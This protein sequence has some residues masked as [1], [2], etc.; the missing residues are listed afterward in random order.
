MIEAIKFGSFFIRLC[1]LCLYASVNDARARA[2][3]LPKNN[4]NN[5]IDDNKS[6]QIN[7]TTNDKISI[8]ST[9]FSYLNLK[10]M[11]FF[12]ISFLYFENW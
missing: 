12:R 11:A 4:N 6:S 7:R 8:C 9:T 5:N 2:M 1:V 10:F 3:I